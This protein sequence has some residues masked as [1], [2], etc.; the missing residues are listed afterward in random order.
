MRA[1]AP[2]DRVVVGPNVHARHFDGEM[3]VLDLDW[4]D[5]FGLNEVGMRMWS[6]LAVGRTPAEV[7]ARSRPSTRRRRRR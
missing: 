2:S 7:G 1:V 3:V 4:G 6:E 5:Y